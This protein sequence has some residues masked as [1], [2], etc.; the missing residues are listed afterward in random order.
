MEPVE[1]I[2]LRQAA[3]LTGRTIE[4]VRLWCIGVPGLAERDLAGRWQVNPERLLVHVERRILRHTAALE[5][6]KAHVHR[7]AA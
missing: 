2:S 4:A 7:E 1:K 5:R 6:V 3:D